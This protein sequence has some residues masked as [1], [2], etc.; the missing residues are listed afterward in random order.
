MAELSVEDKN[1]FI[2]AVEDRSE[3]RARLKFGGAQYLQR[4]VTQLVRDGKNTLPETQDMFWVKL[5]AVLDELH[6]DYEYLGERIGPQPKNE[7][8]RLTLAVR[9][10]IRALHG[11][12]DDDERIWVQYRRDSVCH[13]VPESYDLSAQKGKGTL[14][15]QRHFSLIGQTLHVDEFDRRAR[16]LLRKYNVDEA[17]M[18]V[19]FATKLAPL[20]TQLVVAMSP[21]YVS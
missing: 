10:T 18:A 6:A 11:A 2:A 7:T 12:L 14:K 5:Y 9:N 13:L 16:A 15:E 4:V 1:R 8:S 3:I 21:L 20:L 19:A 17:A